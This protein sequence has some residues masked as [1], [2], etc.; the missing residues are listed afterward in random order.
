[1]KLLVELKSV[2]TRERLFKKGADQWNWETFV[3]SWMNLLI[4]K[5]KTENIS[6]I[7]NIWFVFFSPHFNCCHSNCEP[8]AS[9]VEPFWST[10]LFSVRSPQIYRIYVY[11]ASKMSVDKFLLF[12]FLIQSNP[13]IKFNLMSYKPQLIELFAFLSDRLF[14]W[15]QPCW[16]LQKA[17]INISS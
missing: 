11:C 3:S 5:L 14:S 6:P 12:P 8:Q 13:V 16:I 4:G 17:Q 1:M 9:S 10:S 15:T 7:S 2:W